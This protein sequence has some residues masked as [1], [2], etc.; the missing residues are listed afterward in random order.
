MLCLWL[1]C[2]SQQ[3][4]GGYK[5][6]YNE[7]LKYFSS[8][9]QHYLD[10]A[11]INQDGEKTDADDHAQAALD[12][13][14]SQCKIQLNQN[15]EAL[16]FLAK[17]KKFFQ[18]NSQHALS[19]AL[20][21]IDM[22]IAYCN[23]SQYSE[24]LKPLTEA[25]AFFNQN[26]KEDSQSLKICKSLA[27]SFYYLNRYEEAA[28]NLLEARQKYINPS[29]D[30][31]KMESIFINI[32]LGMCCFAQ[33]DILKASNFLTKV[34]SFYD[35][36]LEIEEPESLRDFYR[37]LDNWMKNIPKNSISVYGPLSRLSTILEKWKSLISSTEK[38]TLNELVREEEETF[39]CHP[40]RI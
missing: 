10:E 18:K 2:F 34:L 15:V 16:D 12:L 5:R 7:A 8:A 29:E 32:G 6:N 21:N 24:A 23:T 33:N 31:D 40:S 20:V 25:K 22:G 39:D 36:E 4:L 14:I 1:L 27:L 13:N 17:A 35:E 9:Q 38:H 11:K 3:Q 30:K 37:I 28:V 26:K 19:L